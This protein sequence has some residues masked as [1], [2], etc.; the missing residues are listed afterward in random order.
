MGVSSPEYFPLIFAIPVWGEEYVATF[1]NL[2]LPTHLGDGNL[3]GLTGKGH[4]YVIFTK[5]ADK[6]LIER[7][8]PYAALSR[9]VRVDFEI[10]D[11]WIDHQKYALNSICYAK[12]LNMARDSGSAAVLLNAD[13]AL[14][15]N[16]VVTFQRLLSLGKRVIEV[17]APRARKNKLAVLLADYRSSAGEIS[18]PPL[19]LSSMWLRNIHPLLTMHF[20]DGVAGT[21]FHPSHLYWSVG[22]EGI[23]A[24]CCHLMPIVVRPGDAKIDF[25]S[26]VD[27]DLVESLKLK[28][29][30]VYLCPDSRELF[31][32]ELSVDDH[33]VGVPS[34]RGDVGRTVS[35]YLST[36]RR[37]RLN[38]LRE[39]L[40][41]A[42]EEP[43]RL[44]WAVARINALRYVVK[45]LVLCTVEEWKG[46]LGKF[47]PRNLVR[48]SLR[49]IRGS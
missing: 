31:C 40:I 42:T 21:P 35:F 23:V 41:V 12:A 32:C 20:V 10:I 24:R 19:I 33:Y 43:N 28:A 15:T 46:G 34:A 16:S 25:T 38:L 18:V 5:Q 9:L 4:R 22:S 13:H 45:I 29:S 8:T 17:P 3:P 44:A 37:N 36:S 27:D 39:S 26:T 49:K 2:C 1:L 14:A 6:D 11:P 48:W 47:S 30:D 7:S